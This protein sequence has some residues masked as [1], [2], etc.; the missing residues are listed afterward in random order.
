MWH[1]FYP[2]FK[3][4]SVNLIKIALLFL[5]FHLTSRF[6]EK[7]TDGFAVSKIASHLSFN[8]KWAVAQNEEEAKAILDQKFYYLSKGAQCYVFESMDHKYVIKFFR[9]KLFYLSPLSYLFPKEIQEK[10]LLKKQAALEK[11]FQSYCLAHE[12]LKEETGL[13][14]LHLN[15]SHTF[16][17]PLTIV[18]KLGIEH[19]I[20]LNEHEFFIQKK[21]LLIPEKIDIE[22]KQ[23]NIEGAKRTIQSLFTLIKGRIEKKIT[24]SDAN[25]K[26]NFGYLEGKAI[27]ID[28]G[29]FSKGEFSKI[30][31]LN[32][33]HKRKEDLQYWINEHY[34]ELST[35][36]DA[37]F[38]RILEE[39]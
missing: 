15:K 26:K 5:A 30:R 35:Y 12:E 17:H 14:F 27:Q 1:R 16:P 20:D 22:M 7:Q 3:S 19:Q 31:A 32:S 10:K 29:R 13:I 24:D 8:P 2:P 21:A 11:D 34:P 37:E 38:K 28:I 18:D 9:Q 23:G 39:T 6:C 4:I 25:L 36:F 33:L